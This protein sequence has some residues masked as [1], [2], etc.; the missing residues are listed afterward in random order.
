MF[1]KVLIKNIIDRLSNS[2]PISLLVLCM[3][4]SW[5]YRKPDW[6]R[7]DFKN[8]EDGVLSK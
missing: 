8:W 3:K 7:E 6:I 4:Y 2:V 1:Q 5:Q